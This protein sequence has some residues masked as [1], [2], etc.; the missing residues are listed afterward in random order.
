MNH[1]VFR[2]RTAAL[3]MS[4]L[5]LAVGGALVGAGEAVAGTAGQ[6]ITLTVQQTGLYGGWL[7]GHSP[8]GQSQTDFIKV[9]GKSSLGWQG[10]VKIDWV[11]NDAKHSYAFTNHCD[12]PGYPNGSTFRC[13]SGF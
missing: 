2:T 12:V 5:V 1:N 3:A 10:D 8:S 13:P 7:T 9:N 6:H 4:T 11:R